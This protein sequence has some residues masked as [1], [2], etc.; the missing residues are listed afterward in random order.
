MV[1][2]VLFSVK[3]TKKRHK[4]SEVKK[5]TELGM[6]TYNPALRLDLKC[7]VGMSCRV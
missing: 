6:H 4:K 7:E 2:F 5:I 3:K 1:L